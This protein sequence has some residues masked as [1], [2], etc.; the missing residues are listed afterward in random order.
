[1]NSALFILKII[2]ILHENKRDHI[3]LKRDYY[4]YA[5]MQKKTII[6]F[7]VTLFLTACSNHKQTD[8]SVISRTEIPTSPPP[9]GAVVLSS[10]RPATT[11]TRTTTTNSNV[12]NSPPNS[13][14]TITSQP[15][16]PVDLIGRLRRGFQIPNLNS[17]DTAEYIEWSV[18]HPTY[19]HDLLTRAEPFL[20]YLL[21]E[22]ER[23]N[24]PTEIALI[25]VIESA[26]KPTA[27]SSSKASGLW[28]FISSTGRDFNLTQDS[29][30]DGR[31]DFL[32]SSRA[33][34]DY[35]TQLNK[36]FD[37]DWF[38][39]LAAYNAGQGTV[40]RAISSNQRAG[41]ATHYQALN[42]REETRKYIPKLQAIKNIIN[43]PAQYN[44]R[45]TSLKNQPYFSVIPLDGQL[46]INEFSRLSG[47]NLDLI[48]H[49]NAGFLRWAT[50]PN[51]PHR[52]LVPIQDIPRAR[53]A[54][55]QMATRP[56][57][58]YH[59]HSIA[60]GESLNTISRKY[61]VSV[62][63]LQ[64]LNKLSG[65]NIRA[66]GTLL[67][68]LAARS[69]VAPSYTSNNT[70]TVSSSNVIESNTRTVRNGSANNAESNRV[71]HRVT[72]GETLWSISQRYKVAIN[73]LLSW[74][75]LRSDHILQLNQALLIFIN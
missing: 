26:Y 5:A 16:I 8:N 58:Q 27:L 7:T 21:E 2:V 44:V 72:A 32:D 19:L 73:E 54:L 23:R 22:I 28:Q 9:S 61:G 65:T 33:A 10:P 38:L 50:A 39:T 25:P 14:R 42:L 43:N 41:R 29:W 68:P 69:T 35:L 31:R 40:L 48:K 59:H 34:L 62:S 1:M 46:D 36:L 6:F 66:G 57:T 45:L 15:I 74:N 3:D 64:G 30:Y 24:L 51:G 11:I 60:R 56:Q 52:L 67:I 12:V 37:G 49:M 13:T 53:T 70:N 18:R 71:I 63:E 4:Y 17:P 47:I 20:Y 55:Q 75:K